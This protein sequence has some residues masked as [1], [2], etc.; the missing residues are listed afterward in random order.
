[1]LEHLKFHLT[2]FI[3]FIIMSICFAHNYVDGVLTFKISKCRHLFCKYTHAQD[4]FHQRYIHTKFQYRNCEQMSHNLSLETNPASRIIC[5]LLHSGLCLL[6]PL[7]TFPVSHVNQLLLLT[8]NS[9]VLS[10][11]A[12]ENLNLMCVYTYLF[13]FL[14]SIR[15][16][17]DNSVFCLGP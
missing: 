7:Q 15:S 17:E 2:D 14:L 9:H 11:S 6:F 3:S 10:H 13:P 8:E 12:S 4:V 5:N 16:L 1:M